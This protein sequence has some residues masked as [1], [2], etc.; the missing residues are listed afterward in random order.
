VDRGLAG[1]V[2]QSTLVLLLALWL[3]AIWAGG[4]RRLFAGLLTLGAVCLAWFIPLVVLSGGLL[5]YLGAS[6]RLSS[7]IMQLTSVFGY[8]LPAA[9]ATFST[10]P[11]P[12]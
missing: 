8:G 3:Y 5:E 4:R 7:I 1:G 11:W 6:R 10:S 2:W 12:C 9:T